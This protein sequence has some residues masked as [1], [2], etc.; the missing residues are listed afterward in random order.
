MK[1]LEWIDNSD[2]TS[3]FYSALSD[4]SIDEV[5]LKSI[6]VEVLQFMSTRFL[7]DKAAQQYDTLFIEV[8]C[9]TGQIIVS[10]S[11]EE[12]RINGSINGCSLRLVKLQDFWYDLDESGIS[13]TEFCE[14]INDK[15]LQI[16]MLFSHVLEMEGNLLRFELK[17]QALKL[18]VFGSEPDK[19]V[20]QKLILLNP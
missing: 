17:K 3:H 14:R 20:F 13:G 5:Q 19:V 12:T 8:N 10:I 11:N 9:D 7:Q 1:T 2:S 18:V 16:G 15:V 4:G 6:V